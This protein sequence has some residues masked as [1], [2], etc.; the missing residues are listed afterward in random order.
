MSQLCITATIKLK[1]IKIII[2]FLL[3]LYIIAARNKSISETKESKLCFV[4]VTYNLNKL[5]KSH[6]HYIDIFH[7]RY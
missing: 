1:R 7:C 4:A 2:I 3:K 5:F 6:E